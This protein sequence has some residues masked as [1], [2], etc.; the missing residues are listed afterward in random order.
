MNYRD[1]LICVGIFVGGVA[2]G[3]LIGW[4]IGRGGEEVVREEVRYVVRPTTSVRLDDIV[5]IKVEPIAL[6][7]AFFIE[8][9]DTLREEVIVYADTASIVADYLQRREYNLDFSTDTTGVF[10]VSAVVA[11]NRLTSAEATI[12]PLQREVETTIVKVRKFRPFVGG[13]VGIGKSIGV[14]LDV[15]AL[16]Y[17]HHLPR[18]GY[19]R[20]GDNNYMTI[21]YG[22]LF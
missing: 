11:E 4:L 6:P 5:P 13:A 12:V 10:K 8:R 21:G 14:E 18:V 19:Q 17:E 2:L 1:V 3:I 20:I 15:G 9:I 22:Y 7:S 16:I